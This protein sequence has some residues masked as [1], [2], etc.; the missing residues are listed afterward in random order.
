MAAR[1]QLPLLHN[2][3]K[4]RINKRN[5]Q[6]INT[7]HSLQVIH[8]S[9]QDYVIFKFYQQMITIISFGYCI[10]SSCLEE[11]EFIGKGMMINIT[12]GS[13]LKCIHSQITIK[14]TAK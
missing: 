7:K 13:I 3:T 1:C 14:A 11:V 4:L 8:C 6:R 10:E 12:N 9:S 2:N 5:L